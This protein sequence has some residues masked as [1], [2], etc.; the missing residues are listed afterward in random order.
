MWDCKYRIAWTTKHRYK[1][2][3]GYVGQCCRELLREIAKAHDMQIHAGTINRNHVH[4]L[5]SIPPSL[6]ISRAMQ[7]LD[8]KRSHKPLNEFKSLRKR[9]W[10]QHLRARGYW[11]AS[12][13]NVTDEIWKEYIE[14]QKPPDL[15]NFDVV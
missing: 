11:V 12:S 10:G 2:F 8:G 13:E 15:D 3:G 9:Y 14:N 6:S 7:H 1:I 4:I 5:I